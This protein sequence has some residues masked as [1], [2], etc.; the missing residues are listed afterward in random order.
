MQLHICSQ[1]ISWIVI[2]FWSFTFRGPFALSENTVK[3]SFSLIFLFLTAVNLIRQGGRKLLQVLENVTNHSQGREFNISIEEQRYIISTEKQNI[4]LALPGM[5]L[6]CCGILCPCFHARRK[7]ESHNSIH[8]RQQKSSESSMNLHF[9]NYICVSVFSVYQLMVFCSCWLVMH[10]LALIY[11]S[12]W[13][14][15]Q[16]GWTVLCLKQKMEVIIWLRK[17]FHI[18]LDQGIPLF[19]VTNFHFL[20][21]KRKRL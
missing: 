17:G 2:S 3:C 5:L 15:L 13:L 16:V 8:E 1:L 12:L 7:E 6:L 18:S 21:W 14:H 4:P 19:Y 9:Q 11:S 20:P 10:R